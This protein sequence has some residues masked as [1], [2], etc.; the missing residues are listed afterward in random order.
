MW[1]KFFRPP[2]FCVSLNIQFDVELL[3]FYP[4]KKDKFS[5][6]PAE[7][8]Q[9]A[10]ELKENGNDLFKRKKIEQAIA[11]YKEVIGIEHR[12]LRLRRGRI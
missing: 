5:M 11:K 2:V 1:Y 12:L 4:M 10:L 8:L 6:T 7:K 3:D 9:T